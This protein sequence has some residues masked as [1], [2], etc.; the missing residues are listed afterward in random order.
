M[1]QDMNKTIAEAS[2]DK[3]HDIIVPDAVGFFPLSSG[4]IIV[5]LLALTLLFHFSFVAYKQYQ[6]TLYKR[7]A[8]KELAKESDLLT[9]LSLAKRVGIAAYGRDK[10]AVLSS[11]AWWDFMELHSDVK[12]EHALRAEMEKCLYDA[13]YEIDKSM[14]EKVQKMVTIWIKT[15]K[16]GSDV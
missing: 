14:L 8:L 13:Q 11:E 12:V 16:V 15:H 6:K 7:E 4:W 5:L 2:L 10:I 9:L 3:L 1:P